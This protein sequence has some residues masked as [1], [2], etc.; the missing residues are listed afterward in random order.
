MKRFYIPFVATM[1]VVFT[2][3]GTTRMSLT[4]RIET[5]PSAGVKKIKADAMFSSA[6]EFAITQP[7]DH[8][9]PKGKKFHQQV[10]LDYVGPDAPVVVITEGYGVQ[11]NYTSELARL[12]HANQIIIEH[13]YF[14]ESTP[15]S[16]DW[17]YLTAW[18]SAT[19]Q[20]DV[21]ELFKPVF[22][23]RWISTGIAMA[24]RM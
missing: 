3:C 7:V 9:N 20:H 22:K 24:E 16:V 10:F 19:D 17:R 18:Q 6:Y 8:N 14:E 11:S 5:L 21:I 15:D 2:G 4:S 23:G 1:L 12:L 13:R